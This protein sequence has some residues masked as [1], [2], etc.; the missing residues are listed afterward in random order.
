MGPFLYLVYNTNTENASGKGR[1]LFEGSAGRR[2]H[3]NFRVFQNVFSQD[4]GLQD[5]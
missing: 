3:A 4:A 5:G 1:V 2:L